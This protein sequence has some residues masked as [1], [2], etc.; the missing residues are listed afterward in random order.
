MKVMQIFFFLVLLNVSF[1]LLNVTGIYY[2]EDSNPS[3]EGEDQN[4]AYGWS[5]WEPGEIAFLVLVDF[6]AAATFGALLSRYGVNPFITSAYTIFLVTFVTL[7]GMFVKVL[8]QIGNTMDDAKIIMDTFLIILTIVMALLML[9]TCIQMAVGG[10]K[11]F[12]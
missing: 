6:G 3:F 10:G 4:E 8:N 1:L 12:E 7:Y 9:Y 5:H 11:G 2:Y